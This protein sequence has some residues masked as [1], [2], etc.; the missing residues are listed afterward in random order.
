ML[1]IDEGD[2]QKPGDMSDVH[3]YNSKILLLLL[4]LLLLLSLLISKLALTLLRYKD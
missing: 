2:S 1:C 4:L 3:I